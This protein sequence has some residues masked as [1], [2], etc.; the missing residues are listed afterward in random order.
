M[1]NEIQQKVELLTFISDLQK[2]VWGF[3]PR[4]TYDDLSLDALKKVHNVLSNEYE[5]QY[6]QSCI[7]RVKNW[8]LLKK[9]FAKLVEMGAKDFRQA[10]QMDMEAEGANGDFDYYCFLK[11]ISYGK[12]DALERL[13][14]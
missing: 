12:A 9:C 13:A 4:G 7:R 6:R 8:I 5:E 14:A 3:R 1:E 11:K 10:L 2:D